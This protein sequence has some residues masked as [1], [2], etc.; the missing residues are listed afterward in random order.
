VWY[1]YFREAEEPAAAAELPELLGVRA[2][3]TASTVVAVLGVLAVGLY[4]APVIAAAEGAVR[5][6]LKA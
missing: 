3:I 1:L 4:P 2:G 5:V 6:F